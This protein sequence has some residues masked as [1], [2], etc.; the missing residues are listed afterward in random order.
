MILIVVHCLIYCF[1]GFKLSEVPVEKYFPLKPILTQI[2]CY[3]LHCGKPSQPI[4]EDI[5]PEWIIAG[6]VDINPQ[7]KLAAI[8]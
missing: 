4:I 1:Y 6:D 8:D 7:I 2:Q 3:L 5:N